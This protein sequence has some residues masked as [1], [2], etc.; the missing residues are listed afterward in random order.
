MSETQ[1]ILSNFVSNLNEEQK[2]RLR[3]LVAGKDEK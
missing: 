3:E 2:Q 1:R